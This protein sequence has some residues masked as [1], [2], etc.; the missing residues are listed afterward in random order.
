M[1]AHAA[2][3]LPSG[4]AGGIAMGAAIVA[5]DAQLVVGSQPHRAEA[6]PVPVLS[7]A[8]GVGALSCCSIMNAHAA[9]I[10]PSDAAGGIAMVAVIVV[11]DAQLDVGSQPHRAE[12]MPVLSAADGVGALRCCC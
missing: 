5:G 3:I 10:L 11:G 7:A 9:V 4:A 1:N 2:V 6:M 12:A 8:D